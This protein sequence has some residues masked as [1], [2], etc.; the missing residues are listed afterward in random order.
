MIL[1]LFW[2][3]CIFGLHFIMVTYNTSLIDNYIPQTVRDRPGRDRMVIRLLVTYAN[4]CLSQL[5][6]WVRTSLRGGV[7]DTTLC[8]KVCQ[9]LAVGLWF[10]PGTL[11]F[12]TNET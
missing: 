2:Q 9:L 1:E 3:C 7:R 4:Q 11:G 8:D 10:S 12:S 5:T 6:L